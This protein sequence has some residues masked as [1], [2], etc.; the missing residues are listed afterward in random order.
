MSELDLDELERLEKAATPGPWAS[1]GYGGFYTEHPDHQKADNGS[2]WRGASNSLGHCADG[3]YVDNINATNDAE[4]IVA[5]RNSAPALISLA[6]EALEMRARMD[7]VREAAD[8]A[9][10]VLP[11]EAEEYEADDDVDLF[12]ANREWLGKT[13]HVGTAAAI[14]AA[15]NLLHE[16]K[17]DG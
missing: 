10:I 1:E 9:G 6:R 15:L 4:L 14:V 8:A 7:V 5:F 3:E 2:G 11:V 16:E 13:E 12:G 17:T